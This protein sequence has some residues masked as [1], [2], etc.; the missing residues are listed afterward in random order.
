MNG[1]LEVTLPR[2]LAGDL[3]SVHVAGFLSASQEHPTPGSEPLEKTATLTDRSPF[4]SVF[5]SHLVRWNAH[6]W[7]VARCRRLW[8]E[9]RV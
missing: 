1:Q 5:K 7:P 8:W 4:I 2:L 9:K 3:R 6:S